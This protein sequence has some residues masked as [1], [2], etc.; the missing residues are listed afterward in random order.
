MPEN[1]IAG[2]AAPPSRAGRPGHGAPGEAAVS[3]R[4]FK[5][6]RAAF[7]TCCNGAAAKVCREGGPDGVATRDRGE[8]CPGWEKG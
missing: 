5:A 4:G 8:W 2:G 3:N 1:G 6:D 7:L